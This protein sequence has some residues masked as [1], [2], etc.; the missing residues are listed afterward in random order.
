VASFSILALGVGVLAAVIIGIAMVMMLA[1]RQASDDQPPA[2]LPSDF[3]APPTSSG[4]RFRGADES[5]AQFK[6]RVARERA[7][8][9]AA[10]AAKKT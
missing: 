2:S 1:R 3:V 7:A 5:E 10:D 6:E 4:S 8:A 9:A